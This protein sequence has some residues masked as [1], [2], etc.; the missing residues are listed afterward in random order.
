MPL[1]E[2]F[3]I[4]GNFLFKWRSYLPLFLLPFIALAMYRTGYIERTFGALAGGIFSIICI[5]ISFFGLLIRCWTI[6]YAPEGTSGRNTD[7]QRADV[8]NTK[9]IYSLVRHPLYLGNFFML[10]GIILF[11]QSYWL[12]LLAILAFW[13]YYERIMFA[14]EEYLRKKYGENF[15]Q[16][17]QR[18]PSFLPRLKKFQKSALPFSMKRIL[19]REYSGFFTIILSFTILQLCKNFVL[20]R[21]FFLQLHW[22]IFFLV[23]FLIYVTLRG[24]K[25]LT[26]IFA[27]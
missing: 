9:G 23:G 26:R 8:L 16:W 11:T 20:Y 13:L 2:E 3:E 1:R 5:A 25:K 6:A 24:L 27:D 4:Q 15:K 18:T 14:E 21:R 7:K 22:I 17:A 12:V 19:R 10:F